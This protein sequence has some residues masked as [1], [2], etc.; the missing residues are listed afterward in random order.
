MHSVQIL[1]GI[2]IVNFKFNGMQHMRFKTVLGIDL[3]IL[4]DVMVHN[5]QALNDVWNL[6]VEVKATSNF[7]VWY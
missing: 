6:S 7:R 1:T 3:T 5:F 4:K 2:T